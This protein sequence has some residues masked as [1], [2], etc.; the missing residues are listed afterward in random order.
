MR[1]PQDVQK[2]KELRD[3]E[4]KLEEARDLLVEYEQKA[5]KDDLP[6][7]QLELGTLL[8][9]M[10]K[11]EKSIEIL[12]Q[13]VQSSKK[14][15]NKLIEA[16]T[17]RRIGWEKWMINKDEKEAMDYIN[18][19]LKIVGDNLSDSDFQKVAA[20][21][22][23]AVGNLQFDSD[24]YDE[25]LE[26]YKKAM[27]LAEKSD[28]KGRI[29]TLNGD[30]GNVYYS[31]KKYDQAKT[32]FEK[33]YE[34][35]KTDYRHAVPSSLIR[36]AKLVS[37]DGYDKKDYSKAQKHLDEALSVSKAENWRR[38][39]AEVYEGY[40]WLYSKQGNKEDSEE[41][42]KKAI[43]IYNELGMKDRVENLER[44]N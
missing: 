29:C 44:S 24:K 1:V 8:F 9:D 28:F 36:L 6:Y 22:W 19:S 38:D 21:I 30:I 40:Y 20:N 16:D 37:D 13:A 31:Q 10:G 34:F 17:L 33:T 27:E 15:S 12:I 41:S 3:K 4:G 7:V 35:A 18:S 11:M 23:A 32:M 25:A 42:K 14:A 43:N 26:S 2:A 39:E 5:S